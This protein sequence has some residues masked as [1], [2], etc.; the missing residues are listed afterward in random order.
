MLARLSY[1]FCVM[2]CVG[3]VAIALAIGYMWPGTILLGVPQ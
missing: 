3:W 2:L 1:A